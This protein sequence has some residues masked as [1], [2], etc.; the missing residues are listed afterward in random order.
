MLDDLWVS[1]VSTADFNLE[2]TVVDSEV[3]DL[4]DA[5]AYEPGVLDQLVFLNRGLLPELRLLAQDF[6]KGPEFV[7]Q[8]RGRYDWSAFM[9]VGKDLGLGLTPFEDVRH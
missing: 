9:D 8:L 4:L 3:L 5:L 7:L 6:F 1:L 2:E